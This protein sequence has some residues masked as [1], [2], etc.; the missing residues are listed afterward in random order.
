[1]KSPFMEAD[2]VRD[3]E[4]DEATGTRAFSLRDAFDVLVRHFWVALLVA[5]GVLAAGAWYVQQRPASY[6]AE[7]L[8]L[9]EGEGDAVLPSLE[10]MQPGQGQSSRAS[11]RE[12]LRTQV[13]MLQSRSLA[14]VVA[15][16]LGLQPV[17][18]GEDAVEDERQDPAQTVLQTLTVEPIRDSSLIRVV[19]LARDADLAMRIANTTATV[20][21]EQSLERQVRAIENAEAWLNQQH[22]S[23]KVSLE[24]SERSMLSY[25]NDHNVLAVRL[26][27]NVSLLADMHSVSSQ[28]ADA[29]LEVD[30]LRT[31]VAQMERILRSGNLL[32]AR[33]DA[34][35]GNAL[36]QDLRS[37]WVDIEVRRLGLLERYLPTHPEVESLVEQQEMVVRTME[38]EVRRILTAYGDRFANARDVERR[39]ASRL[40]EVEQRVQA[41][42]GHEVEYRVLERDADANR[43]LFQ[44]VERRL[45]EVEL[46]RSLQRNRV[47]VVE[48]ARR[49]TV[50]WDPRRQTLLAAIVLLALTLGAGS[51]FA[52]ELLDGSVQSTD[53]VLAQVKVPFVGAVPVARPSPTGR[54]SSR[55]PA[56]GERINE[57]LF[58]AEF[59]R[60]DVAEACRSVRTSLMFLASDNGLRKILV[61][62]ANPQDG[63]T[64]T[65]ANLGIVM[66]QSGSRILL[67][68]TDLRRPCLHL[69]FGKNR[70][71]GLSSVLTRE[72]TAEQAIQP[73]GVPNL[74]ILVSGPIPTNP[75][76]LMLT[77]RFRELVEELASR[78]DRV[79]FDSP[80]TLPVTDS[81]ILSGMVDGVL[82]VARAG[83]TPKHLLRKAVESLRGVRANLLGVVLNGV[84]YRKHGRSGGGYY[85]YYYARSQS[86]YG[87]NDE[88]DATPVS[89]T[90]AP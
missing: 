25:R 76:E 32:D 27:E 44:I 46:V 39:L 8:I 12:Y 63:K 38:D 50:P 64:T 62:S 33:V 84:D 89:G 69:V 13:L 86:Y 29:R 40:E 1:M 57:A 42:G 30:R 4:F 6:R 51:A 65:T 11:H 35:V 43:E 53:A 37:R 24:A 79:L 14:E 80:P 67:V 85:G 10:V 34:V 68:D 31:A 70:D 49:P 26:S 61:T 71:V 16:R 18:S 60:S 74:D 66:A 20:Y 19:A 81:A 58:S 9:L 28:L 17:P 7:A 78:Y 90:S 48:E 87:P 23:L 77:E 5:L 36:I 55:G 59:P 75:T 73:T 47:S 21:V 83:R 41:L 2:E 54:R 72:V 56:R 15:D 52:L 82:F 3:S 45:K 88:E 22:A